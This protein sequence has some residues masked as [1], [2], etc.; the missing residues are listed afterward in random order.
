MERIKQGRIIEIK[1]IATVGCET[2]IMVV[3]SDGLERVVKIPYKTYRQQK[4]G[5]YGKIG[6]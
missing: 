2:E 5:K 3:F 6:T 1:H 4:L